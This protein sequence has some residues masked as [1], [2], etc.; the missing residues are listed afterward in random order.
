MAKHRY[1]R[2]KGEIIIYF[3]LNNFCSQIET[4]KN[5]KSWKKNE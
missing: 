5:K 1:R 3:Y 4:N 2:L